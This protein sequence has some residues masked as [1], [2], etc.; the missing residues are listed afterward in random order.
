[1][2]TNSE[3]IDQWMSRLGQRTSTRVR[4]DLVSEVNSA[5][6][7]LEVQ[8]FVPWFLQKTATLSISTDDVLAALPSDFIIERE[9]HRPYYTREGTVHYL[10]KMV[11][12][13]IYGYTTTEVRPMRYAIDGNNFL[14]R[15][16]ADQAYTIYVPYYGKTGGGFVDDSADISNIWLLNAEEWV[17][18][19]ALKMTAGTHLQNKGLAADFVGLEAA[20]KAAVY[21]LHIARE[22]QNQDYEVGGISD[23]S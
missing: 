21:K 14:F 11:A 4:A 13:M 23:G 8:P 18:A 1:M 12:G 7:D 15:P 3:L 17:G 19:K 20:Q 10:T 22:S 6:K 9:G 2:T 5:I 16:V